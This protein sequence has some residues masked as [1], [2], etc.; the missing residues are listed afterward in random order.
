MSE[1][2]KQVSALIEKAVQ[3]ETAETAV[4]YAQAALNAAHTKHALTDNNL[5]LN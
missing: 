4:K 2:E 5:K 3:A 1:I